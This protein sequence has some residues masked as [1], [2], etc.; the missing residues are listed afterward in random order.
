MRFTPALVGSSHSAA[1]TW[2]LPF[3]FP[4]HLVPSIV[5]RRLP[6]RRPRANPPAVKVVPISPLPF[7]P[8]LP[9]RLSR[10]AHTIL[11]R[12]AWTF[13]VVP[14][15][16]YNVGNIA[17]ETLAGWREAQ[18]LPNKFVETLAEQWPQGQL[19]IERNLGMEI[20][21]RTLVAGSQIGEVLPLANARIEDERQVA[22]LAV[23]FSA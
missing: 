17:T 16:Y 22:G 8:C 10:I 7:G 4:S 11:P 5:L 6:L 14:R 21:I 1:S 20:Y 15:N 13:H 2:R 23:D 19:Q 18:H 9:A 12:L 3:T